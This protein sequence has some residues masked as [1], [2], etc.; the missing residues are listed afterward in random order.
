MQPASHQAPYPPGATGAVESPEALLTWGGLGINVLLVAS[1]YACASRL[2]VAQVL[3]S[4]GLVQLAR[5]SP[6]PNL[7]HIPRTTH[8]RGTPLRKLS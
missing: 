7:T 3:R 2:R 6:I 4:A 1:S 8:M 5:P